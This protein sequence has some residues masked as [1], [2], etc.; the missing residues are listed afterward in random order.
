[1]ST[2]QQ[3]N[4]ESTQEPVTETVTETP[5]T[6]T[7]AETPISTEAEPV[8]EAPVS[9]E[10]E[11]PT[12]TP[13]KTPAETPESDV[14][15][16]ESLLESF[17][18]LFI[19]FVKDLNTT[20]PE[21][22]PILEE[23]F[24]TITLKD[25]QYCDHFM[26]CIGTDEN[27]IRFISEKNDDLFKSE[28]FLLKGID[29]HNLWKRN[30]SGKTREIMWQYIQSMYLTGNTIRLK[31]DSI[32]SL[33]NNFYSMIESSND[34]E[35]L[36][37]IDTQAQQ[38]YEMINNLNQ[39]QETTADE[40]SQSDGTSTNASGDQNVEDMLKNSKI[41][42]LATKL[43]STLDLEGMGLNVN[44]ETLQGATGIGDILKNV[45]GNDPSKMVKLFKSV[46]DEIQNQMSSGEFTQEDI[47][48]ETQ[49]LMSNASG[50]PMLKNMMKSL[51]K[52]GSGGMFNPQMMGDM[53]KMMG[54]GKEGDGKDG[55][56]NLD[57]NMMNDM[58][59]MMG[60]MFGGMGGGGSNGRMS[61][62][63]N[64]LNNMATQNR[65]KQKLETRKQVAS[66]QQQQQQQTQPQMGTQYQQRQ[67]NPQQQLTNAQLETQMDQALNDLMKLEGQLGRQHGIGPHSGDKKKKKHKKHKK[68]KHKKE[69]KDKKVSTDGGNADK[70]PTN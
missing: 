29:F 53:M 65:L 27:R 28:L 63:R 34:D 58:M 62:D 10:A 3:I 11:T 5:V 52:G 59:K 21:L 61:V 33:V 16:T 42:K 60:G 41:G 47:L 48:K 50:N 39:S 44:Q 32:Q 22:R 31:F 24:K 20:Y 15:S 13:T 70:P 2:E 17:N 9:T 37:E 35:A 64:K 6:E 7:V 67:M 18:K 57:P 38:M 4:H 40:S 69:K 51:G 55:G 49:E 14:Q 8:A 43:T 46:G 23:N 68:H 1:M 25:S 30:I 56:M 12:E 66:Q 19:D 26:D 45:M 36:K 54:G